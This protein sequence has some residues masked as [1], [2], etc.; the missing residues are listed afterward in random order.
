V[1]KNLNLRKAIAALYNGDEFVNKVVGIPGT[2]VATG[3]IPSWVKGVNAPFRK[4]FPGMTHKQDFSAAKKYLSAALKEL[5][6]SQLPPLTWLTG[7]T[8]FSDWEAQYFQQLFKKGLGVDLKIDKQ[9][10]KQRLAKMTSGDFDIVSAGW[11]PD[12]ADPMTF[13]DLKASWNENNR[14]K[15]A[16]DSYDKHIRAAQAT[17]DP[18]KRMAEMAAAE[19]VGL[20]ELAILPTYERVQAYLYQDRVSGVIRNAV[21]PDPYF[22]YAD[23]K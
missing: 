1:T 22:V 13:A 20:D 3:L 7:D 8:P 19:K 14:G 21:G 16:S 5:N 17:S 15:Y 23:V 4:E 12:Y 2:K 9:I 10:F 18:K 11:G 6:L